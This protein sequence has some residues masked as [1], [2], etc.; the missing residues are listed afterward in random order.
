MEKSIRTYDGKE[1]GFE[2]SDRAKER[3]YLDHRTLVQ[4]VK[5]KKYD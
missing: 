1:F 2:V 5:E 3:G 4:R